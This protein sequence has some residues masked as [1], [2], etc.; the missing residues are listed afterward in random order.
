MVPKQL[1]LTPAGQIGVIIDITDDELSLQM[2]ALQ[3][4]LSSFYELKTG[5]SHSKWGF[6]LSELTRLTSSRYRVPKNNSGRSDLEATSVG[7]LDGDFLEL[8]LR[9]MSDEQSLA[10]IMEGQS[11]PERL[12]FAP[13]RLQK[14]LEELQ[15]LH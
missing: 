15:C 13:D 9:Y 2:T 1:F 7:F 5:I 14:L 8:F 3:R 6:S 11:E 12:T 4:N 10:Q